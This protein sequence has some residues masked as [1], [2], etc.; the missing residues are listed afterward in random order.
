[1]KNSKFLLKALLILAIPLFV[2]C[3]GNDDDI[4]QIVNESELITVLSITLIN[5]VT[6]DTTTAVFSDPDGPGGIPPTITPIILKFTGENDQYFANIE[7][8]DSSNPNNL[9]QINPE[10]V[11]EAEMHQFFYI[12]NNEAIEVLSISYDPEEETDSNGN[13]LGI[14][15]VW[16][17]SGL[18]N[19]GETVTVVLRHAPNKGAVLVATGN[20][21]YAGGETDIEV[22]FQLEILPE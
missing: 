7:V 9:K 13:P 22:T 1:M 2:A 6:N 14:S 3:E 17:V 8:L 4:P 12:P 20:I 5:P 21:T 10:I 11:E 16:N 15:S 19:Q 18:S